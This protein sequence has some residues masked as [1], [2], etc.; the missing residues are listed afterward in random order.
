MALALV[1]PTYAVTING[2][3]G[4]LTPAGGQQLETWLGEGALAL[5]SI[6]SHQIGD[7]KT[8]HDFHAAADGQGRTFT[9]L[10]VVSVF[11]ND[12][13]QPVN[14]VIG[15]YNPQS[16]KSSGD[17]NLTPNDAERTATLFNLTD[18]V[19]RPQD[20]V[21]IDAAGQYQTY[22]HANL[23]PTFGGGFDIF[24][25][26]S[27]AWGYVNPFSYGV[28]NGLNILGGNGYQDVQYGRMEVFTIAAD[29]TTVPDGGRT[30]ALMGCALTGLGLAGKRREDVAASL[31]S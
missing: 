25:F 18:M 24:V 22:N 6:F 14:E 23:G 26:G 30:L 1:S 10:E 27:L 3:I 16:W 9:I 28:Y 4:L 11:V 19:R 31:G 15:G 5:T 17:Y 21:S 13:W 20:P 29:T 8:S 7:G 2:G 12:A